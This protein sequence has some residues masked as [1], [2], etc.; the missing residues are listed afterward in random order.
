MEH[1]SLSYT[2][3]FY[4]YL[5]LSTDNYQPYFTSS[6][7]TTTNYQYINKYKIQIRYN[8]INSSHLLITQQKVLIDFAISYHLKKY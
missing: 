1:N 5:L 7:V 8:Y 4:L 3:F 6:K 2:P